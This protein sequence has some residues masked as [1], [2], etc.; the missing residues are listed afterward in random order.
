MQVGDFAVFTFKIIEA[1]GYIFFLTNFSPL[2]Y[3][4]THAAY[5]RK[6]YSLCS[7]IYGTANVRGGVKSNWGTLFKTQDPELRVLPKT[8]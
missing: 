7:Y 3:F 2:K 1:F 5:V 6:M 4:N 8:H